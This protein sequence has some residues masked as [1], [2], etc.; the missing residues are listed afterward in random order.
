MKAMMEWFSGSRA[1]STILFCSSTYPSHSY[2]SIDHVI[3]L[4]LLLLMILL[5][6]ILIIHILLLLIRFCSSSSPYKM[7]S[8]SVQG[9]GSE[10]AGS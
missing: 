2:A 1:C 8:N 3:Y 9:S 5:L 7:K 4:L 6:L 10:G